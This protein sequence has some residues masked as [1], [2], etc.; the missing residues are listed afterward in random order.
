MDEP[1]SF[2]ARVRG[3]ADRTAELEIESLYRDYRLRVQQYLYR[4]SGSPE[5]AEE[6]TQETFIRALGSLFSFRG[7][8]SIATW[9]FRIARNVY[10]NDRRRRT[11][12]RLQTDE[13]LALPDDGNYGDPAGRYAQT[14]AR[15]AIALAL[16]ELPEKQRTVLLSRDAEGL[17]YAEIAD[18]LGISLA[19]VKVNLFRAR[20]AFRSIYRDSSHYEGDY[21]GRI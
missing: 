11:S 12:A 5:E 2:G 17:A 3:A 14:E 6:L 8:C 10:L 18:V 15:N 21:D 7:E 16:G 13:L 19:A 9:L 1:A 20:T 4:M